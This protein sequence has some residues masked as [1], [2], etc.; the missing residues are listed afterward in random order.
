MNRKTRHFHSLTWENHRERDESRLW[1]PHFGNLRYAW[2]A[3]R[4]AR[5]YTYGYI[6]SMVWS[7]G[8]SLR[9]YLYS[10]ECSH[11]VPLALSRSTAYARGE[12]K[13]WNPHA[14]PF[15][16]RGTLSIFFFVAPPKSLPKPIDCHIPA[17]RK[18]EA[19]D[20]SGL[21]TPTLRCGKLLSR[22]SK[23]HIV[24]GCYFTWLVE[25]IWYNLCHTNS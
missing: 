2:A 22:K 13:I 14:Y 5:A 4:V 11:L 8:L 20:V 18:N 15:H 25:A 17:R 24:N 21:L 12:E 6:R 19:T 7:I 9:I 23:Y 1:G 10:I 16:V 3:M